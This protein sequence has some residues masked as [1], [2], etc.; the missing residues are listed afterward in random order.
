MKYQCVHQDTGLCKTC[1]D[2]EVEIERLKGRYEHWFKEATKARGE[3]SRIQGITV[4]DILINTQGCKLN[5]EDCS[6]IKC[7][8]FFKCRAIAIAIVE[9]IKE[10]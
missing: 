8:S 10:E 2:Y 7:S 4:W 1:F 3:L 6:A 5:K 9:R